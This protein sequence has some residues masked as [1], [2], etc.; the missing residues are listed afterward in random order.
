MFVNPFQ[1]LTRDF[2]LVVSLIVGI[3]M[4]EHNTQNFITIHSRINAFGED[5]RTHF[6]CTE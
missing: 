1:S 3:R 4:V 6:L 2:G 5:K